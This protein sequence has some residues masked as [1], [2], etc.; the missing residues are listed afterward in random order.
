[1]AYGLAAKP[2]ELVEWFEAY[3]QFGV[4]QFNIYN[5]SMTDKLNRV[6]AYYQTQG[7][8]LHLTQVEYVKYTIMKFLKYTNTKMFKIYRYEYIPL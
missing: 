7:D 4:T 3:R 8:L 2:E 6:F 5:G 1:V